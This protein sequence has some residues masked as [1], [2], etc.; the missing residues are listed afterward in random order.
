MT[1]DSALMMTNPDALTPEERQRQF[2][3]Q[4]LPLTPLLYYKALDH[5]NRNYYDAE[6]LVQETFVKAFKSWH[7]FEQGSNL[8]AWMTTIMKNTNTNRVNKSAKDTAQRGLEEMEDYQLADA[9]SLSSV[10]QLPAD[11]A[12][13]QSLSSH[14]VN[15]AMRA[16]APEFREVVFL[17]IVEEKP[18]AEIAEILDIPIGTVMSRLHRGKTKLRKALGEYARAEGYNVE[19]KTE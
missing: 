3:E 9:Q 17:A 7:Q 5:T 16:L 11:I 19:G 2:E 13:L 15:E 10:Q 1:I 12:A 8:A 18:Y 6:D 14:E 4:A